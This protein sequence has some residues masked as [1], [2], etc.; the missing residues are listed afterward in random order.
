MQELPPIAVRNMRVQ[1]A[2]SLQEP[3]RVP[4]VP[5]FNNFFQ[6][7]Y[8]VSIQESMIHPLSMLDA[9]DKVLARYEPDLLNLPT[10]FPIP[11]M[12]SSGFTAARWAGLNGLPEDTP[13][14][15][16]RSAVS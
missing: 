15:V 11:A 8:G 3:D 9:V 5:T 10:A 1:T 16:Y 4:F 7:E 14:S 12:E 6:L 13:L 2:V